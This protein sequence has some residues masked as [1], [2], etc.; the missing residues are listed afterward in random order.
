MRPEGGSDTRAFARARGDAGAEGRRGSA[1]AVEPSGVVHQDFVA[2]RRVRGP[3]RQLVEDVEALSC[4]RPQVP[5]AYA[6]SV[7]AG[8]EGDGAKR[9]GAPP[10][11]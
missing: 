7:M 1:E 4:R 2:H 5:A 9:R 10:R 8:L 6:R 11:P 3:F